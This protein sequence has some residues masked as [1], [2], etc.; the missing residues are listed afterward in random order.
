L[1]RKIDD[2]DGGEAALPT[3]SDLCH[4][5]VRGLATTPALNLRFREVFT[6]KEVKQ[7]RREK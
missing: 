2:T 3:K 1:L 5:F 6:E 4:L 7:S